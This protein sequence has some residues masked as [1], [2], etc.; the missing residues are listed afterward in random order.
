[1]L[2]YIRLLIYDF[3]S[4]ISKNNIIKNVC[5]PVN[6]CFHPP[7][8]PSLASRK[9]YER[10]WKRIDQCQPLPSY[11]W[12]GARALISLVISRYTHGKRPNQKLASLPGSKLSISTDW[13]GGHFLVRRFPSASAPFSM[14]AGKRAWT[15]Y[16]LIQHCTVIPR[17]HCEKRWLKGALEGGHW[18]LF[19]WGVG[20]WVPPDPGPGKTRRFPPENLFSLDRG[21]W[22]QKPSADGRTWKRPPF[23][24]L[25]TGDFLP[26]LPKQDT[27][28]FEWDPCRQAA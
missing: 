21:F 2:K 12:L 6:A 17:M 24:A 25:W 11:L 8:T 18:C 16:P 14:L 23:V 19:D 1:M 10:L 20:A 4:R 28:A 26:Q 27:T 15:V 9:R 3:L 13:S 5:I 22:A 7:H